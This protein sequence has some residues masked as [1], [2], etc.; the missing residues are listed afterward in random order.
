MSDPLFKLSTP[1]TKEEVDSTSK[2]VLE[3][4][5]NTPSDFPPNGLSRTPSPSDSSSNDS[6]DSSKTESGDEG[7][8][9][10]EKRENETL[11]NKV[12]KETLDICNGG[13]QVKDEDIESPC[14]SARI[15]GAE[16]HLT[17]SERICNEAK[18]AMQTKLVNAKINEMYAN[19]TAA[20]SSTSSYA[21]ITRIHEDLQAKCGE[22][23]PSVSGHNLP[24]PFNQE[25]S[26][27]EDKLAYLQ[28]LK[29]QLNA[30]KEKQREL[31]TQEI[32]DQ[33]VKRCSEIK[34]SP[35][36]VSHTQSKPLTVNVNKG[37]GSQRG[38]VSLLSPTLL[39]PKSPSSAIIV[40]HNVKA[41]VERIKTN[42]RNIQKEQNLLQEQRYTL[43]KKFAEYD[44]TVKSKQQT[45]QL[46]LHQHFLTQ[47]QALSHIPGGAHRREDLLRLFVYQ[48]Q[49][50]V[51]QHNAQLIEIAQRQQQQIQELDVALA[52]KHGEL[53][54]E[55]KHLTE[56]QNKLN[57]SNLQAHPLSPPLQSPGKKDFSITSILQLDTP[58][59]PTRLPGVTEL[60]NT[61][62]TCES[63]RF[64]KDYGVVKRKCQN[65]RQLWEKHCHV[66]ATVS[67]HVPEHVSKAFSPERQRKISHTSCETVTSAQDT[68]RSSR[69]QGT[70][71]S[72]STAGSVAIIASTSSQPHPK[73]QESVTVKTVNKDKKDVSYVKM[74]N[75]NKILSVT[76]PGLIK[77][78][79]P[80][81]S[82]PSL[83]PGK[84]VFTVGDEKPAVSF[85]EKPFNQT[86]PCDKEPK[87]QVP[88]TARRSN[89]KKQNPI[90]Y[91]D[92]PIS[93]N[94]TL[95]SHSQSEI[96]DIKQEGS[97]KS[98]LGSRSLR[99]KSQSTT[100]S[101]I[102][103]AS[104]RSEDSLDSTSTEGQGSGKKRPMARCLSVPGWFGKGL[105]IKRKRKY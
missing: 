61:M 77:S 50:L 18:I 79:H 85:D 14:G 33:K 20:G 1:L 49:I 95:R 22:K 25:A 86:E 2:K 74:L 75:K 27:F 31:K 7:L 80:A 47:E 72:T 51:A 99:S 92:E 93:A 96:F 5:A 59:S 37:H 23:P 9:I 8:E 56:C 78:H 88:N 97:K 34:V 15:T 42:I 29:Q 69:L 103:L 83:P 13:V 45:E 71:T 38:M 54:S 101:D 70:L 89:R 60:L 105:N 87:V 65:C 57:L 30:L 102:D 41:D 94:K 82:K 39:S 68:S 21:Q 52:R 98:L 35:K 16:T 63:C 4:P 62:L 26:S 67:G 58:V 66:L 3:V 11:S 76:E 104:C 43:L 100:C 12:K 55:T 81:S 64:L 19:C 32:G 40:Q 84:V 24:G 90:R 36:A 46:G 53:M 10:D 28:M 48:Q 44:Q 6:A 91:L 17:K 73:S